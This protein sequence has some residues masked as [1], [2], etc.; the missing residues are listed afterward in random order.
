MIHLYGLTSQPSHVEGLAGIDDRPVAELTCGPLHAATT[1]HDRAPS[2]T[3][4]AALA[5]AAT[6]AALAEATPTLPV[7][8][9]VQHAHV[10]G[11]RA[12]LAEVQDQLVAALESVGDAAEFVVRLDRPRTTTA[13]PAARQ[14]DEAHPE[15]PNAGPGY[16]YLSR[17]LA[18]QHAQV[19]QHREVLAE[20]R[21]VTRALDPQA[22]QVIER[23]GPRGPERCFL[24]PR[25]HVDGF[26]EA[27]A[28]AAGALDRGVWGGP[29]PPYSFVE[30]AV[31]T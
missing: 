22:R 17:R 31:P 11:L 16:T 10:D 18:Q 30:E 23:S 28:A 3:E 27:A 14:E 19:A 2:P 26:A 1:T 8:F 20:L 9:G 4:E 12:A 21:S 29:W 13:A 7:R 25:T 24:V 6:V 5:H 15:S